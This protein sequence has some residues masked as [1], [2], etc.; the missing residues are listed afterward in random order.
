MGIRKRAEYLAGVIEKQEFVHIVTHC[1]ADGIAGGAIAKKMLDEMGIKNDVEIL[2]Y[3]DASI[4]EGYDAFT[5]FIDLGNSHAEKMR[6]KEGII[7]DHHFSRKECRY[8]LN[9]FIYGIDGEVEISASGL[10]HLI[11]SNAIDLETSLALIGAIGDLQDVKHGK[12]VG[13]NREFLKNSGVNVKKDFR[14]YG[15]NKPLFRMLAYCSD[16]PLPGIFRRERNAI[17]FLRS[18]NIDYRKT[19]NQCS[20]EEK[21]RIFSSLVKMMLERGF[22]YDAISR[23]FG[24]VYEMDGHDLREYAA[25]L[26]SLGKYGEGIKAIEMC[27]MGKFDGKE[28]LEKHR[29]KISRYL[30]YARERMD[31]HNSIYYFHGDG[32]IIDTVLGTIAGMILREGEISQPIVAF[33]ENERGIK[34][35]ARAPRKLVDK[36]LNLSIAVNR[37]A[38]MLGGSGGGHRAAAGAI[39][40]R[41]KETEFLQMLDIEIRRQL[42]L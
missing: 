32:Y 22:G 8:S 40:P 33:A 9:P 28:I 31:Q 25:I 29:K 6:R 7:A 14:A 41:G 20:S 39:I 30:K 12:F 11:A 27:I 21:K 38:E 1:D 15:H 23:L 26:N 37:S 18:I 4:M 35:S 17:G 42:T 16:P 5:W 13:M 2:N 10:V 34:V 24:E 3:L 19:W 36:G